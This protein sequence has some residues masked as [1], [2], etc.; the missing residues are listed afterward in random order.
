[1]C[2]SSAP[3]PWQGVPILN[4][5]WSKELILEVGLENSPLWIHVLMLAGVGLTAFYTFRM[6]W[7]V[8]FGKERDASACIIRPGRQ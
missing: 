8:F 4:G 1:M 7:L 6:V 3:W 5:F 2:S